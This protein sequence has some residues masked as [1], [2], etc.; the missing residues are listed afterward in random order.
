MK[1]TTI[2][3]LLCTVVVTMMTTNTFAN[4]IGV[5]Q[6]AG[7]VGYNKEQKYTVELNKGTQLQIVDLQEGKDAYLINAQGQTVTV[8][9]DYLSISKIL[10]ETTVGGVKV[11]KLPSAKSTLLK[12]LD[13][14]QVVNVLGQN[15]KWYNVVLE[16]GTEGFIYKSQLSDE[17]LNMIQSK[18]YEAQKIEVLN[19]SNAKSVVPRGAIV[20]IEDV[21][22]G[23]TFKVKRTFGTNHADVEALTLEDT[24]II[25]NIWG[26]FSWERRPVIVHI[27]GRML[28]AALAGMPH[29][30]SSLNAVKNNGMSGVLDLHFIGSK[31][32]QEGN[33]AAV[34][35]PQ[36]QAAIKVAAKYKK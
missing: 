11:R 24:K 10:T 2:K 4:V 33:I 34:V 35:D 32:H 8:N 6:S 3:F 12:T 7:G 21:Y 13:S 18:V 14:N 25:K 22:T 20:T 1:T 15:E 16:D 29:A 31:R 23:K 5:V 26:G 27:N 36:H 28:A 30:G 17:R 9:K 19:W